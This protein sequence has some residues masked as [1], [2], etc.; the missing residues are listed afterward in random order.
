MKLSAVMEPVMD[1]TE[2]FSRTRSTLS[3]KSAATGRKRGGVAKYVIRRFSRLPC[4]ANAGSMGEPRGGGYGRIVLEG[5]SF[6]WFGIDP[7]PPITRGAHRAHQFQ[8]N[9][10]GVP[11]P[12]QAAAVLPAMQPHGGAIGS[13]KGI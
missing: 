8:S 12:A 13:G 9:S 5:L 6:V 10:F 4:L 7:D 1:L 3:G 2:Q 11:H